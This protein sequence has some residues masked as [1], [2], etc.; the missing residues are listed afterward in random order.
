MVV[1]PFM[2]FPLHLS[3]L[4]EGKIMENLQETMAFT[5]NCVGVSAK[6]SKSMNINSQNAT[7]EW[8]M[9]RLEVQSHPMLTFTE[10]T[11]KTIG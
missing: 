4:V 2:E 8:K 9:Q 11:D 6:P 7:A 1:P 5:I 10:F 3:G